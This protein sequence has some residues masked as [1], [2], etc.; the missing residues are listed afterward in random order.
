MKT[1]KFNYDLPEHLIAQYPSK[2]RVDSRL[3]V[4]I[5]EIKHQHFK[6][7]PSYMEEGDLLV[8]NQTSVIPARLFV[9]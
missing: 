5:D 8:V 1:E 3:L 4:C 6:D 9:E 7:L 2:N